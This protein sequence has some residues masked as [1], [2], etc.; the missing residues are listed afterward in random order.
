MAQNGSAL[1]GSAI[2]GV[3]RHTVHP[4]VFDT[5]NTK[6]VVALRV[7]HVLGVKSYLRPGP[8]PHSPPVG[9]PPTPAPAARPLYPK[10]RAQAPY[11]LVD[12][13]WTLRRIPVRRSPPLH[14]RRLWF[15]R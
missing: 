13:P 12:T 6:C 10:P 3:V 15:P 2:S 9:P 8:H 7:M 4:W 5:R 11:T 1:S 14:T